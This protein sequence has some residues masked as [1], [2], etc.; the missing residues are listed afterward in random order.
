MRWGLLGSMCVELLCCLALVC[1]AQENKPD[2]SALQKDL[3]SSLGFEAPVKDNIPGG[4][5]GNPAGTIVAD[6]KLFHSGK[7]SVR[8]QRDAASS[9]TF[10][11]ITKSIPADFSGKTIELRGFLRGENVSGFMGLW[12]R[13]DGEGSGLGFDNMQSRHLNGTSGWTEYSVALPINPGAKQ[14]VFGVLLVGTGK[15]WADD[16]QLLVDGKPVWEAPLFVPI[17]TILDTDHQFD[18]GS[19]VT[20]SQ[21]SATQIDNLTTL[22]RVWGF[23]KYHHPRIT[24]GQRHWDY[25]LFRVLPSV[26]AAPDRTSAN[27]A[28][29][30]WVDELGPVGPCNPCA[31]LDEK[32]LALRHDFAWI[33]DQ[34]ALGP[35][36][37][38]RLRAILQN[39]SSAPQFYIAM[40]EGVGNPIFKHEPGY[41]RLRLPDFG[42]QLLALYRFWSIVEYW[43]P[44]RDLTDDAWSGVLKT[45]IP[46]VALAKDTDSYKLQLMALLA[47]LHDGHANLWNGLDA[48]PPV[49]KCYLPFNIRFIEH[50]FVVAGLATAN[51]PTEPKIGDVV[52]EIDGVPVQKLTASWAPY[53]ATSNDAARMRDFGHYLTRG[54]CADTKVSVRRGNADLKLTVRRVSSNINDFDP[55]THDLPGPAFRLLSKDVAYLKLSAVKEA[56]CMHYVE[57]AA[58]TRGFIIDIRNYPSEFVVFALGS[59]LVSS[60]TAFARFTNGDLSNPGSFHWTSPESLPPAKPHYA[61]KV[62]VLVDESSMSQSEYTAMAFRA[63]PGAIVVGSTTSGADG[64]V[65]PISLPG[66]LSTM[67]SGIGVFYPDKK[68][69]QRIGILPDVV[70]RPTI[71]G[72]RAGRDEVLEVALRQILGNQIAASEIEKMARH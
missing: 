21:L 72:I 29:L 16:L 47:K 62:V 30:H 64:N 19:G 40:A 49:G 34:T 14:L 52:T 31:K 46:R 45:S 37:S 44:Y 24:G 27:R 5:S 68:P 10:S 54:D 13:E 69:T 67:I 32:D 53:Y 15:A 39:R 2:R 55:G 42:F 25:D 33:T 57:Q 35:D 48:R 11:T 43:S 22:G 20:A 51:P 50:S 58:G 1:R 28:I 23:L 70:A 18:H 7:I 4:W 38:Q 61:G 66:G 41:E 63:A 26:L 17:K 36:L 9:S 60:E 12:L 3:E 59:L 8:L 56:D 6:D 71:A 65:S